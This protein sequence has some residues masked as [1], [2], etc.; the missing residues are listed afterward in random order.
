MHIVHLEYLLWEVLLTR[1]LSQPIELRIWLT[2][3]MVY[4][5]CGFKANGA[6]DSKDK[7]NLT[8]NFLFVSGYAII[9]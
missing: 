4:T 2:T 9:K 7:T 5:N 1:H 3:S 6:T 8:N